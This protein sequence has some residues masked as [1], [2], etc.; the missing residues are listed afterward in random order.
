MSDEDTVRDAIISAAR[1]NIGAHYLAGTFGQCPP[2]ADDSITTSLAPLATPGRSFTFITLRDWRDLAVRATE[3]FPYRGARLRC[4]GRY[5]AYANTG[6]RAKL[7]LSQHATPAAT[8]TPP[9]R[10]RTF[11]DWFNRIAALPAG[12]RT[13]AFRDRAFGSGD[14]Y[15]R[16]HS[17]VGGNANFVYL[18][19]DCYAK[20]HFDCLGFVFYVLTR[21]LHRP[22]WYGLRREG[23]GRWNELGTHHTNQ[24]NCQRGDI[25][26]SATH[27]AFV[28]A[29][30]PGIRLIHAN[31]DQRGVEVT[32]FN[33]KSD[34]WGSNFHVI[35]LSRHFLGLP[36]S[37][38]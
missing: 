24:A 16:R 11:Y 18:G 2:T 10:F 38:P 28:E 5:C 37:P 23:I 26:L 9:A 17:I 15:P 35:N 27:V 7:G 32:G 34:T 20:K 19:E 33:P 22:M 8:P 6:E 13:E 1:E 12:S 30:S 21:V 14:Y 29:T 31:G 3:I 36:A 4:C 25:F